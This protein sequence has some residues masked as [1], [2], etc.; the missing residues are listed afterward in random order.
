[1][2][3]TEGS[4]IIEVTAA[5]HQLSSI[6]CCFISGH[7]QHRK[8]S[9]ASMAGAPRESNPSTGRN[10]QPVW[11]GCPESPIPAQKKTLSQ[12]GRGAQGVQSQLTIDLCRFV[13]CLKHIRY[14][15]NKPRLALGGQMKQYAQG[16]PTTGWWH[17][18]ES[19]DL[20]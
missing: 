18:P 16:H 8:K 5:T 7:S 14:H 10:A 17:L 9:S 12:Y 19:Q 4:Y 20:I 2:M 13:Q 6:I 15:E 1:M 11:Q 3:C